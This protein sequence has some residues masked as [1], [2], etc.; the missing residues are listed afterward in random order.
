MCVVLLFSLIPSNK[1]EFNIYN[2]LY[3]INNI[4]LFIKYFFFLKECLS[5]QVTWVF[6]REI[7]FL[8]V[9]SNRFFK[10]LSNL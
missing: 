8:E 6:F 9:C 1:T 3:T 5:Y 2:K 10:L 4:T 7:Y